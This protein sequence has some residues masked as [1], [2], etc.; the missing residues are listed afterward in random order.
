GRSHERAAPAQQG[1]HTRAA[2]EGAA[3]AIV[4]A[5]RHVRRGH[6]GPLVR[7]RQGLHPDLRPRRGSVRRVA[8]ARAVPAAFVK[9]RPDAPPDFFEA[10]A[11]G[12]RWLA[13]AIPHGG[14]E[15]PAVR[16]VSRHEIEIER[17]DAASWTSKADET[18]GRALAVL[19]RLGA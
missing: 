15:V 9:R 19:H 13:E 6:S 1:A 4:R 18:F 7:R 16:A 17:I 5:R 3:P 10:E 14:P 8:R 2:G 11:A 12:L